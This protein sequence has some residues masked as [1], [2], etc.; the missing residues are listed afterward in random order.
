MNK[1]N[2]TGQRFGRLIAIKDSGKRRRNRI[3]WLCR[4]D[5]GNLIEVS[6]GHLINGHTHSCGCLKKEI[7]IKRNK[8][9]IGKNNPRYKHGEYKSRL[10]HIYHAMRMRC[11]NP[12]NPAYKYYGK[13]GIKVCP[14]WEN[15]YLPFKKWALVSGY[16]DNL[17]ID[18]I[19]NNKDYTP[20]NCQWITQSE[21]SRKMNQKRDF[22]RLMG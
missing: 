18:R 13:R 9:R 19:D 12:K 8:L 2:L 4:C 7:T 22:R 6:S 3:V 1:K 20:E 14:E 17:T 15:N 11:I 10:Y 21:N 5:C 16:K